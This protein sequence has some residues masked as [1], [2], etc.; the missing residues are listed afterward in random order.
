MLRPPRGGSAPGA[1]A[2]VSDGSRDKVF[3]HACRFVMSGAEGAAVGTGEAADAESVSA[4]GWYDGGVGPSSSAPM[5]S[6][7]F[8][9]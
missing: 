3:G 4:H 2:D 8:L 5:R 1:G 6:L 9:G 7:P